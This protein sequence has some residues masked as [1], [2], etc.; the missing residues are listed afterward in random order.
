M[1]NTESVLG[2]EFS[3]TEASLSDY[4]LFKTTPIREVYKITSKFQ[5]GYGY[6]LRKWYERETGKRHVVNICRK[7]YQTDDFIENVRIWKD[8][9]HPNIIRL[10]DAFVDKKYYYLIQEHSSYVKLL[11]RV[12]D[13]D[14][15]EDFTEEDVADIMQQAFKAIEYCHANH[16]V[17][18]GLQL[19]NLSLER[20]KTSEMAS[21][22]A[23]LKIINFNSAQRFDP[24][25]GLR[26]D[27]KQKISYFVAPEVLKN[28]YT[29]KSDIFS[30]G[31]ILYTLL[32]GYLPFD[33]SNQE[34]V[35]KAIK[36]GL[37]SLD[38]HE[39]DD[40][41]FEAKD[42]VRKCLEYE[43]EQR[44]SA[45]EALQ[46]PW[47]AK[48]AKAENEKKSSLPKVQENLRSL[49]N[50]V[51][52]PEFLIQI[53]KTPEYFYYDDPKMKIFKEDEEKYKNSL[54]TEEELLDKH[55]QYIDSFASD[56]YVSISTELYDCL[57]SRHCTGWY[58]NYLDL[59]RFLNDVVMKLHK[60]SEILDADISGKVSKDQLRQVFCSHYEH[61]A[62][63]IFHGIEQNDENEISN[64]KLKEDIEIYIREFQNK[65]GNLFIVNLKRWS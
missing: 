62:S 43:D 19:Q 28:S 6:Y 52:L 54:M 27:K 41:S 23:E 8:L 31:V 45:S 10:V 59:E 63:D 32:V 56:K 58:I 60:L 44:I 42:L 35:E 33:G 51:L 4:K 2:D 55:R 46:H 47:F 11:D 34:E 57:T 7:G 37:Y 12:T 29:E 17:H 61:V 16:I 26:M 21:I 53:S 49:H 36:E 14:F 64:K 1:E 18:L 24:N 22:N 3:E 40:V 48:F 25:S 5:N 15:Y 65:Y 9:D 20:S 39:W 50:M 38:T 13:K 30:L